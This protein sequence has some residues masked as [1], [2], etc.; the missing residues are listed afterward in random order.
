MTTNRIL[1]TIVQLILLG[2]TIPL[3]IAMIKD[4][5]ENGL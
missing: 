2:V 3:L 4:I 5:K 1:T